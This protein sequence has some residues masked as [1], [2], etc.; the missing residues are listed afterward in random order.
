MHGKNFPLLQLFTVTKEQ[1]KIILEATYIQK[2]KTLQYYFILFVR[3]R[4]FQFLDVA[5]SATTKI[6]SL[7]KHVIAVNLFSTVIFHFV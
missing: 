6:L 1:F 5:T 4:N 3:Y 7:K 2:S